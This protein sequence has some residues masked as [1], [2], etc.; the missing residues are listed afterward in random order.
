MELEFELEFMGHYGEP[1][2]ALTHV[3][4]GEGDGQGLYFL[5]YN[6]RTGEWKT[7]RQSSEVADEG[8]SN[9]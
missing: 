8:S 4:Q 7:S 5:A 9:L 6:P 3:Y 1:N 2:L